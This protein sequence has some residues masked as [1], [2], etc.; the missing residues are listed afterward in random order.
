MS[1]LPKTAELVIIGGGVIG[2]S[3]AY[4]LA[5]RGMKDIVLVEGDTISSGSTGRCG[6]GIR[7][8]WSTPENVRLAMAS[9]ER[10]KSLESELETELEFEQGGYL[11]LA[12]SDQELQQFESNVKMQK[13]LNLD[14]E[15]ITPSQAK[16]I[17]PSLNIEKI[18]GATWCPSDGSINPFLL[19]FAY[20][21][22]ARQKGVKIF[23]HTKVIGIEHKAQKITGINTDQ[24][25][26]STNQLVNAAGGYAGFI[27]KLVG[28]DLPVV[29]HR[30]EILA[31]EQINRFF[32]NMIMSFEYNLYFRQVMDGGIVGGQ[33]NPGEL[34]GTDIKSGLTFLKEMSVKL[35]HFIPKLKQVKVIRQWAGLYCTSPDAQPILGK[36]E[37]LAGYYQA[38][39]FSGHGLMLAPRTAVLM[40]NC[41]ADPDFQDEDLSRLNVDRFKHGI[42]SGERSVV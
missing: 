41:I 4:E 30:H 13:S 34:P 35:T 40:A 38:I 15:L 16:E 21:R 14:V 17:V 37:N 6:G 36:I 7:A 8:Q 1:N 42:V 12:H 20:A 27:G 31:T 9:V 18:T 22:A 11:I 32:K 10:F 2:T 3:I 29:P 39:G 24:G 33:T 23:Q 28:L 5:K 19:N 25:K 26:I